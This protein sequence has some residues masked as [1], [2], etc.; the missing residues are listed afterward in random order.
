[1]FT[2]L[3]LTTSNTIYSTNFHKLVLWR[4]IK[5]N[6]IQKKKYIYIVLITF[7]IQSFKN[8]IRNSDY[9]K[10]KKLFSIVHTAYLSPS[11]FRQ[12]KQTGRIEIHQSQAISMTFG[13]CGSFA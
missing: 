11:I 7:S 1:M 10:S 12:A 8:L 13:T 4:L 5:I 6:K 3:E 9:V 2:Y